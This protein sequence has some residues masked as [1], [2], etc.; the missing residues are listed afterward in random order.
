M[1]PERCT[2]LADEAVPV[3]DID[4][5]AVE[6]RLKELRE[7]LGDAKTDEQRAL[8]A[9]RVQIAEAM[10]VAAGSTT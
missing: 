5:G 4:R 10:L 1:T 2:V 9:K 7:D 6:G 3:K 8:L